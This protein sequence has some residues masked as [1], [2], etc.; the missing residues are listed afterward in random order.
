MNTRITAIVLIVAFFI[1][2]SL[3][4]Q[5]CEKLLDDLMQSCDNTIN[6]LLKGRFDNASKQT[7]KEKLYAYSNYQACRD[8]SAKS[9]TISFID[10]T[11]SF[12]TVLT[13][14]LTTGI[15]KANNE[16][17]NIY[18]S[19][20][21]VYR[22]YLQMILLE[23]RQ[24]K[25]I[26]KVDDFI[27]KDAIYKYNDSIKTDSIKDTV[28][29]IIK[30]LRSQ[31]SESYPIDTN[32]AIINQQ[33]F[34]T[35]FE[36]IKSEIKLSIA[37]SSKL[38]IDSCC[39]KVKFESSNIVGIGAS[40]YSLY[41]LFYSQVI[42]RSASFSWMATAEI[43]IP[44]NSDRTKHPG[45]FLLG[46]IQEKKLLFQFGIGWLENQSNDV[47]WKSLLSYFPGKIGFS[48]QYSPLTGFGSGITY[49]FL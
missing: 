24:T 13:G 42:K 4:S 34:N 32:I 15:K 27:R 22:Q 46:G 5:D 47:S 29:A 36:S 14:T 12:S 43:I 26:R 21:L 49:R 10:V 2:M 16:K 17:T 9:I 33:F 7:F 44:F 3:R 11:D 45:C 6:L 39:K 37:T 8:A 30:K 19:K 18:I 40:Q 38:I 1:P 25:E 48:L 35:Q 28:D 41:S 31:T 23:L 20:L